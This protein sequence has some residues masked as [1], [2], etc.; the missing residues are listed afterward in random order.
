[1]RPIFDREGKPISLGPVVGRGGEAVVYNLADNPAWIAKIYEPAPRPNYP[2]KLAWMLNNPPVDPTAALGHPSLAWPSALL[3]DQE[4]HLAGYS[5]P[6]I[7]GTAPILVVFNP[8]RRG[9]TLP[10]FDRRYLHR[11]AYNL[12]TAIGAL[13]QS[14][15][16]VGD[17]N[18]SN[19]LV[20]SSA[21]VSLI[22]TDSFQVQEP[23]GSQMTTYACPVA[24]PE[25]TPPE[26]QGKNLSSTVRTSEQD[27]FGLGILIFQ[28]LMEGNHPFRAQWLGKGDPPP[29]EERIASGGF[30]YMM[31]PG[32]PVRPPKYAP[33][34]DWL[35]PAVT[36]LIRR[37]FIDGHQDPHQRPGAASWARAIAEAEKSLVECPNKHVYSNHLPAC[38]YCHAERV[39]SR[40]SAKPRPAAYPTGAQAGRKTTTGK[41][42]TT[43]AYSS[44]SSSHGSASSASQN[45]GS[46]TASSKVPPTGTNSKHTSSSQSSANASSGNPKQ[47]GWTFTGTPFGQ[48]TY[49]RPATGPSVAKGFKQAQHAWKTYRYWQSQ[50]QQTGSQY[51]NQAGQVNAAWKTWNYWRSG[52][53]QGTT[54]N[55][56]SSSGATKSQTPPPNSSTAQNN[57]TTNSAGSG[58]TSQAQQSSAKTSRV[59]Q[60]RSGPFYNSPNPSRNTSFS[61]GM[62]SSMQVTSLW[63]W[64]GPRLYK[65]LAIGGGL[66]ALVGAL[67][68]ALIGVTGWLTAGDMMSWVLLWAIGGA[69]AGLLRGWLPGYRASL[70]VDQSVGWRRVL[71]IVGVLIGAGLGGLMGFAICW[72]AI[73]PVFIGLY[74]GGKTGLKAGNKLWLFGAQY[75]W[76]RIWA[77]IAAL[78]TGLLGWRLA[79]WLGAGSLST[80]LN[81]SFTAWITSQSASFEMSALAVGALAGA[82]GGA[83]AGTLADLIARMFN[84]L[85]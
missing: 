7:K 29:L 83:I 21:L 81:S 4:H 13:H 19:I 30:P 14:N 6:Y 11:T 12:A 52:P 71:P 15:Y 31:T 37:C 18:E 28:L 8:R 65:S 56:P 73:I 64:A 68:G 27:A 82:L 20:K 45:A 63:N 41:G 22:D 36:E 77:C 33:E 40:S 16:I 44:K 34:L 47:G 84:L 75:G 85:D 25:Y 32:M 76:D 2:A 23:N 24:K 3:Y 49:S 67:S 46:S 79:L 9:E 50:S 51:G 42:Q 80:Q 66:G 55:R 38:P 60:T 69:S 10:K 17:L 62:V 43:T 61:P 70:W 48:G 39:S 26:L 72:W 5:M 57:K 54:P 1:M 59:G 78:F 74:F 53:A 58:S 35:H